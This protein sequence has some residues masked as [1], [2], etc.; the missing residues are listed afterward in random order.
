MSKPVD[1]GCEVNNRIVR[2]SL[3]LLLILVN[4]PIIIK[5]GDDSMREMRDMR[6][7]AQVMA[8]EILAKILRNKIRTLVW[9][10]LISVLAAGVALVFNNYSWYDTTIVKI[11]RV[12]NTFNH[13][14]ESKRGAEKYY[15][16]TLF[17]TVMNG[18]NKGKPVTLRNT[19]SSS[20][21]FDD[22][23]KAGDEVFVQ[24]NPKDGESLT[25]PI[26][27]LK[28]D[29]IAAVLIAGFVLLILFTAKRKGLFTLLS[30]SIN[31]VLFIYA[32][33]LYAHG[34]NILFLSNCL[35]LFFTCASLLLV[36]GFNKKTFAAI[37]SALISIGITMVLFKIV[38]QFTDGVDYAFME[39]II[40]PNDLPEIFFSQMLL[41]GLGAIMDVA[42]TEA[43]AMDELVVK[44]REIT[45]SAL[46]RSGR[47]V[48]NDIMGT[49]INVMLFTYICGSIPLIV[50]K[51]NSGI[52]LHTIILWHL[53]MELYRFLL[54]SIG[55]V[56][57]IP[58]SLLVFLFL[59]RRQRR[60]AE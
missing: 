47:E 7:Q 52:R 40:S 58:V 26:L 25:G 18:E 60:V 46:I 27:G 49:M 37:L 50:L 4:R 54:G 20:G 41:G 12:E 6:G 15:D 39:Y 36:A 31:I 28:R 3:A 22:Q 48:G 13:K 43:S 34:C 2:F 30:L 56:L 19:F 38:L 14:V 51:M 44:D 55:I 24:T 21:V 11:D 16:Q 59:F 29:N 57:T 35:A 8:K 42:I 45:R 32:L 1:Y 9:L 53:P 17:G 5:M 33:N 10:I 23:Y